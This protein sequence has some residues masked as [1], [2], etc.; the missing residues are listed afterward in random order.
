MK[1]VY[2]LEKGHI[3]MSVSHIH[4]D[5]G[6]VKEILAKLVVIAATGIVGKGLYTEFVQYQETGMLGKLFAAIFF[7]IILLFLIGILYYSFF[8]RDWRKKIN[9][10]DLKEITVDLDER[11]EVDVKLSF[12]NNK[13]KL[14]TFRKLEKEY[15]RFLQDIK[16]TS[17]C[18][19]SYETT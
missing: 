17:N 4:T 1:N 3:A 15:E 16:K 9:I 7:G 18:P 11:N 8:Q 14:F 5:D 19:I 10:T 13:S 12:Q 6:L 2:Q